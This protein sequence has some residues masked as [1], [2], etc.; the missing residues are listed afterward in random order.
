MMTIDVFISY[1]HNDKA[2]A[3]RLARLLKR[4]GFN[5][6]WD[7]KIPAGKTWADVIEEKLKAAK[8]VVG[9]WSSSSV[10]SR[11]VN[12]SPSQ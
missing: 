7:N 1:N 10:N 8:A 6:W 12:S 4:R 2:A 3:K 9:L 5:V 11:W